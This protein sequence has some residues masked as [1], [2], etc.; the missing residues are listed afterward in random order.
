MKGENIMLSVLKKMLAISVAMILSFYGFV[1]ISDGV[2][3]DFAED[4]YK[5]VI[6]MIGDG[7]GFN[8]LE[9]TKL[10]RTDGYL[11]MENMCG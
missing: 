4:K 2:S 9:A 3:D 1:G 10:Y 7:M 11:A 5:N 8:N 6:L